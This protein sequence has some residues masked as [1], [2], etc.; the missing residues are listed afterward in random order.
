MGDDWNWR[1]E[2]VTLYYPTREEI[3]RTI[4]PHRFAINPNRE[5]LRRKL[6]TDR[7][8]MHIY[9]TRIGP[10]R[11]TLR[12]KAIARELSRKFGK[13]YWPRKMDMQNEQKRVVSARTERG[14]GEEREERERVR[15]GGYR[16]K[17][18]EAG[19]RSNRTYL[20]AWK[21]NTIRDQDE[22]RKR[23]G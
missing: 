6:R 17:R 9:Q 15:M 1:A 14:T 23:L 22:A 8:Y 18:S 3:N 7:Y 21:Q 5:T 19:R 2:G 13:I 16:S 11:R 10:E 4:V 20:T 12:S